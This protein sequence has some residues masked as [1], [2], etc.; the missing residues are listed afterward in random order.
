MLSKKATQHVKPLYRAAYKYEI[1]HLRDL[2]RNEI[3]PSFGSLNALQLLG[4]PKSRLTKPS[5]MMPSPKSYRGD[6]EGYFAA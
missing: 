4:S 3:M 1:Q 6:N 2:C 5:V